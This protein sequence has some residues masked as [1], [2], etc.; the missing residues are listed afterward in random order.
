MAAAELALSSS[1]SFGGSKQY[2]TIQKGKGRFLLHDP[3]G[4]PFFSIG[5]NHLD[6]ATLR[7]PENGSIWQEKY[8]NSMEEWLKKDVRVNL[9]KWG[10]NTV[11]WTQEVVTR[12]LTNHRHSRNFTPE[13]YRWLDMPYCHMLH[14]ADFHQWDAEVRHPDFFKTDFSD[15]CDYVARDE[16]ARLADDPNL[17]GYFY[18]DCPTW[19]HTAK[20]SKWKGPIFDPELLKT[21]SEKKELARIATQYYKVTHE[22]VRRYDKNHLIFGDRY[23]ALR[24]L[25]EEVIL[26]AAPYVD[27]LS[28]QHFST[29][30]KVAENLSLWHTKTGLPTLVAD[31]SH[32]TGNKTTGYQYH[33]DQGYKEV[34]AQLR[35]E[36]SC[37]GYHLCGAYLENRVRKKGLLTEQEKPNEVIFQ[38]IQKV[39]QATQTWATK[40]GT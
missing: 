11:G 29:P 33:T 40:Q 39:N 12:G 22:A 18:L 23:E 19:V 15:W 17:I 24:L 1:Y 7:Y 21:E 31:C 35:N 20:E 5:L 14:F 16:A 26:A 38:S 9:K 25:A 34:Y 10:F 8:H 32:I 37:L 36:P 27:V 28:F 4:K 3:K 2:F 13:E 30:A 6:S